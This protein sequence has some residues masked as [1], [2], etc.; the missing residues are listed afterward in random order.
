[1]KLPLSSP[2]ALYQ[3]LRCGCRWTDKPQPV[4]CPTCGHVYV[5]W[6]NYEALFGRKG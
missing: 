3:C 4:T 6:V 5:L 2:L 1:M